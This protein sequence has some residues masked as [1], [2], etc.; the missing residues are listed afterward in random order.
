MGG[1]G[2]RTRVRAYACKDASSD[3]LLALPQTICM[4]SKHFAST[5]CMAINRGK[6][7]LLNQLKDCAAVS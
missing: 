2:I 1:A 5:S 3:D 4:V 6:R 7:S